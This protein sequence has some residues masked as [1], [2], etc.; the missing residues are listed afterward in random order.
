MNWCADPNVPD[1]LPIA[2]GEFKMSKPKAI[3]A[4]S[5]G[6]DS[7]TVLSVALELQFDIVGCIGF[8]YGSK[9]NRYENN[10]AESVAYHYGLHYELID[11]VEIG[12]LLKSDLLQTGGDIPE[13]HYEAASM[14]RTVVPGRN[15]IFASI[16][17]G[18]AWTRDAESV[19]MGIHSGDHAIYPD[20][21]PDFAIAMNN[22]MHLGTDGKVELR[23]PFL[24]GDKETILMKGRKLG[25][26]YHLTRTCYKDQPVACGK[27]GSCQERLIAFEKLGWED[28]IEYESRRILPKTRT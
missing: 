20:C 2:S 10:S 21:R 27:C 28:P 12:L 14:S 26:P 3:V 8:R 4:L 7:A 23:T 9:H 17:A 24:N 13:G 5:G 22:A 15:V 11:L 6:M 19:W 1:T 18:I 16:L 25:T